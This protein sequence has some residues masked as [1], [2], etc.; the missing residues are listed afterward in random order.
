MNKKPIIGITASLDTQNGV[1]CFVR[2]AYTSS[3]LKA[4]GIPFLIPYFK[5]QEIYDDM[6]ELCDGILFA[7]GCDIEP[8]RYGENIKATC[9]NIIPD[10]DEMDFRLLDIALNKDKPIMTICR[11]T[12]LVNIYCGGSLYQDIPTEI[13]TDINHKQ[14]DDGTTPIHSVDIKRDT[15]L[16][17]LIKSDHMMVNS[18]HHQAVKKLGENLKIMATSS[19]GIIESFYLTNKRYVRCYQWHPERLY[20][21][22]EHNKMLFIDFIN[23]CKTK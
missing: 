19:D 1:S 2:H 12:Q 11:G 13:K 8:K 7:G 14:S 22:S 9:G 6:I 10:R 3:I 21:T 23:A 4:G 18:F 5:D 20:D 17:N 15:P 16:F